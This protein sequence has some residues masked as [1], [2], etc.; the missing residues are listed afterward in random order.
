MNAMEQNSSPIGI[1][2]Y[3]GACGLCTRSVR[4]FMRADKAGNLRFA[5]LQGN[6]AKARLPESLRDRDNLSTVVY[7][8]ETGGDHPKIHLR[9]G[10]VAHA[11]ID[12]GGFWAFCGRC[13][14]VVPAGLSDPVYNFIAQ[15]RLRIFP[16]G[17]CPLPDAKAR[18]R[19]LD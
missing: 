9:S 6:T 1:L 14:R 2:F 10:A 11:L 5:P 4:F 17:A 18:A 8:H 16:N 13:L 15:H 19:L 12:V 7:L 3:D